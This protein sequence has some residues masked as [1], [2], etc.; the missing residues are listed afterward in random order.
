MGVVQEPLLALGGRHVF[1]YALPLLVFESEERRD[2]DRGREADECLGNQRVALAGEQLRRSEMP[3]AGYT[4]PEL[5]DTRFIHV[6][7][8]WFRSGGD[9]AGADG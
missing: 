1:E 5:G 3:T 2:R 7:F 4:A 9:L 8:S 6:G